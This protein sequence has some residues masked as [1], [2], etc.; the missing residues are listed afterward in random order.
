M[1]RFFFDNKLILTNQFVFKP[2]DSCINQ[3]FSITHEI[4]KSF[5]DGLEVRSVFLDISKA[6]D[7][8]WH[9]GVI[10]KLKQNGIS[11]ALL[12]ILTDFL[13]NRKQR[14]VLNGQVSTWTT[15]N[16]GVPQGSIL[17]PLLFLIYDNDLSDNLSSNV[18]LFA[19]DTSLFSVIHDFN[20]SAGELNEDLKK[21][22]EWALQWEMIFNPDAINQVEEVIFSRRKK[23]PPLFFNNAIVS[24]TNSQKHLGVTLDLK[25]TFEEHLLNVF[26]TVDRTIGFM[27]KLQ[28]V[29]P[30][31][32]LV[33]IYE[34]F[35]RPHLDYGNILY[36]Q[37]FN[38]FFHDRLE[39]ISYNACF[40]IMGATRG[41][42]REKLYQELGLEPL[43][44][45]RWYRK[46]CLSYKVFKSEHLQYL[47]HLIPVRY[48]P[49]TSR[50][51]HN[52]PFLI[53]K[54]SFFKNSFLLLSLN[55]INWTLLFAILKVYLY[56]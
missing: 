22:S 30:R 44:L 9:E 24:Q 14:V 19:D 18:K 10:L 29:L 49:Y 2:D 13:S 27:R 55:G 46:L 26:K 47:F 15:I 39:S 54:H 21:I 38:N 45:R 43:R 33:T 48:P 17:G 52:I 3:L 40:P 16:A 20:I 6:F 42:S 1:F 8:V 32:T 51:V 7:K 12:N 37:A 28:S 34:A 4:Y 36:D 50:N 25:L 56:L 5:D 11:G 53:V 31:I 41:T 23:K 35:V